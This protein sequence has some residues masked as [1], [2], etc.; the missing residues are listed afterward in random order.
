MHDSEVNPPPGGSEVRSLAQP[1]GWTTGTGAVVGVTEGGPV[2]VGA[3]TVVGTVVVGF[4]RRW[5]AVGVA[6]DEPEHPLARMISAA[7]V[8]HAASRL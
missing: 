3:G 4:G 1:G 8:T 2:V 5:P 6:D 7:T